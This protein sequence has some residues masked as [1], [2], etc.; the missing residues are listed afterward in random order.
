MTPAAV[1]VGLHS[2]DQPLLR[3]DHDR[4]HALLIEKGQQLMQLQR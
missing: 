2:P 4:D 3:E 1:D